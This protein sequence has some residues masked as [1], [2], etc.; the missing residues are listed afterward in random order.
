MKTL[1]PRNSDTAK[2][3][4]D[5]PSTGTK[6]IKNESCVPEETGNVAFVGEEGI[7]I[8]RRLHEDLVQDLT[9]RMSIEPIEVL[10]V[11]RCL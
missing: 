2:L 3:E 5:W 8:Q 11:T 7:V 1:T 9:G 4:R 6:A 10:K